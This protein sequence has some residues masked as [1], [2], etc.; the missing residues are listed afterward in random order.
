MRG[1]EVLLHSFLTSAQMEMSS[2]LHALV[3]L[4]SAKTLVSI[5]QEAIWAK[6]PV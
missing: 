4:S 3:I 5:T 6:E 2:S 1:A